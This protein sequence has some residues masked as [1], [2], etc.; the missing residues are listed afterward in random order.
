MYPNKIVN[1][2]K[3][4]QGSLQMLTGLSIG[5]SSTS[6]GT[7]APPHRCIESLEKS[8]QFNR[9]MNIRPPN[10]KKDEEQRVGTLRL[11]GEPS[12]VSGK[13]A[14]QL[15]VRLHRHLPQI[16]LQLPQFDRPRDEQAQSHIE[17]PVEYVPLPSEHLVG[18]RCNPSGRASWKALSRS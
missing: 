2:P 6:K 4:I 13:V 17:D 16:R 12:A 10:K 1:H 18:Q 14:V 15:V 8:T 5:I 11:F 3:H 7:I 9:V